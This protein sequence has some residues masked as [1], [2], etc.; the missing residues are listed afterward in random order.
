[1]N[2]TNRDNNSHIQRD[3]AYFLTS[4]HLANHCVKWTW[5]VDCFFGELKEL[6]DAA[7]R[8]RC[9]RG[10]FRRCS[11]IWQA[12]PLQHTGALMVPR[13]PVYSVSS[14]ELTDL[15]LAASFAFN[16]F[17]GF[18][19]FLAFWAFF[20]LLGDGCLAVH[21]HPASPLLGEQ[22]WVD[23]RQD[24]SVWYGYP[25]QKLIE[26]AFQ[27]QRVWLYEHT[28][29]HLTSRFFVKK[30]WLVLC[31]KCDCGSVPA[32]VNHSVGILHAF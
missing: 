25:P 19:G 32:E 1:M 20:M 3:P 4:T 24:P 17:E 28:V 2:W 5:L 11:T 29:T 9:W 27:K 12:F 15:W 23:T 26:K 22:L 8:F 18:D 13:L 21:F 14:V 6:S 10:G 7:P 30:Q 31:N 16:L